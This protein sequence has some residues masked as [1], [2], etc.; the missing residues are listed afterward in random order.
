MTARRN[1]FTLIELLVVIAI[2]SLLMAILIPSLSKARQLARV[3]VCQSN[4]RQLYLATMYYAQDWN[5][6]LVPQ[7]EAGNP[8]DAYSIYWGAKL[9][10]YL[11]KHSTKTVV[12][13]GQCPDHIDAAEVGRSYHY[14]FKMGHVSHHAP[15]NDIWTL[16]NVDGR[17]GSDKPNLNYKLSRLVLFFDGRGGNRPGST[18]WYILCW[19]G[20]QNWKADDTSQGVVCR[21]RGWRGAN[22]FTA[23]GYAVF[24]ATEPQWTGPE[25]AALPW[26]SYGLGWIE[27]DN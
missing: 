24:V 19:G 4:Q 14:N 7:K 23:G 1:A 25:L 11:R 18:P 8:T 13:V 26:K 27:N 21:H 9:D 12:H 15:P 3:V 17:R 2:V 6:W 5:G 16:V 10:P 22:F 20:G